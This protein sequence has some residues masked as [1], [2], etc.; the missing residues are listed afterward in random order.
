MFNSVLDGSDLVTLALKNVEKNSA[1]VLSQHVTTVYKHHFIAYRDRHTEYLVHSG[2]ICINRLVE[3]PAVN[4]YI[5][6]KCSTPVRQPQEY[7][8]A[9]SS[10]T[11]MLSTSSPGRFDKFHFVDWPEYSASLRDDQIEVDIKA[12]G[13]NFRDVMVA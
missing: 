9:K 11:L 10:R 7:G 13:L 2:Q 6:S 12:T 4:G 8:K 5:E 3:A 1:A